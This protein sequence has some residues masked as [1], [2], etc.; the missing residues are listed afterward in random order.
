MTNAYMR[1]VE[2]IES[3]KKPIRK[4]GN[5]GGDGNGDV[6]EPGE[7]AFKFAKPFIKSV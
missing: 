2:E 1:T 7:L 6:F 4:K 3:S 5:G